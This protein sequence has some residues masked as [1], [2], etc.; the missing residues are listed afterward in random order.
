V[1]KIL[2]ID[3]DKGMCFT[4]SGM[5]KKQGHEVTCAYSLTEGVGEVKSGAYDVVFLDVMMPDGN[6]LNALPEIRE[7]ASK[8]EVIIITAVGDA[9]GAELRDL[10]ETAVTRL[11]KQYLIDL[12]AHTGS[13]FPRAHARGTY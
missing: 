8:P 11:E 4:L 3:D 7:T 1:A 9:D 5:V 12:I 2:I 6:G 13:R 10:R